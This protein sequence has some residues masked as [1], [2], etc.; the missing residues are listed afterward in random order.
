LGQRWAAL[1]LGPDLRSVLLLRRALQFFI[2]DAP[3]ILGRQFHNEVAQ[4]VYSTNLN[5]PDCG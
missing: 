5:Q 4:V 3:L 1:K 2:L